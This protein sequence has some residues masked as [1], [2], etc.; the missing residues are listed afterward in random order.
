MPRR[1]STSSRHC[2]MAFGEA[3]ELGG[4][5]SNSL[6]Q[7]TPHQEQP[8]PESWMYARACAATHRA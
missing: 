4:L 7:T 2:L 8:S 1:R 5:R 3:M 6:A